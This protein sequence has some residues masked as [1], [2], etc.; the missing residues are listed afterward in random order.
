MSIPSI[1]H[2]LSELDHSSLPTDVFFGDVVYEAGGT[3]GPRL[4]TNYQ[5]LFINSGHARIEIDGQA[6]R[7]SPEAD[8]LLKAGT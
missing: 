1:K 2:F 6:V 8:G 3:Y 4:Q 7:P 5:L